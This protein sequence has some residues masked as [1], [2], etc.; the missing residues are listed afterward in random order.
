MFLWVRNHHLRIKGAYDYSYYLAVVKC[1]NASAKRLLFSI[2]SR[3]YE[4]AKTIGMPPIAP[5]SFGPLNFAIIR[6]IAAAPAEAKLFIIIS[7][8]RTII[9]ANFIV[10]PLVNLQEI[11]LLV[12]KYQRV[13]RALYRGHGL[14]RQQYVLFQ[15]GAGLRGCLFVYEEQI[16]IFSGLE[17]VFWV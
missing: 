4:I 16:P 6:M 1:T 13:N 5:A 3:M 15:D 2:V 12:S 8:Q 7:I 17:A 9:E 11:Y 10:K 14:V